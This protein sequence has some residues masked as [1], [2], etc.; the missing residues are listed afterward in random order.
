MDTAAKGPKSVCVVIV[1]Y[2]GGPA[3]TECV[4]SLLA[5]TVPAAIIVS[6]RGPGICV[7]AK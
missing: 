5:S 3:L 7:K 1:N 4:R 6:V 2:N